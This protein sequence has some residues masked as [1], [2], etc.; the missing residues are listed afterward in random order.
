MRVVGLGFGRFL[1]LHLRFFKLHLRSINRLGRNKFIFFL[2]AHV[3]HDQKTAK[4]LRYVLARMLF[5]EESRSATGADFGNV[6]P[7]CS[8][9]SANFATA[10]I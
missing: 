2:L 5:P 9:F 1:H 8:V 4:Q 7:I 10:S 3:E 6:H